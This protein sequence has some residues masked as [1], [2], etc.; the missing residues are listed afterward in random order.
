MD[1]NNRNFLQISKIYFGSKSAICNAKNVE[2][3]HQ[4]TRDYGLNPA[5]LSMMSM[6]WYKSQETKSPEEAKKI[7][8][9]RAAEIYEVYGN[10]PQYKL[11]LDEQSQVPA[12][13]PEL[14]RTG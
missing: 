8:W 9:A 14:S 10:K 6:A 13:Q 12:D 4:R 5:V 7:L 2:Q 1:A 3:M 11:F